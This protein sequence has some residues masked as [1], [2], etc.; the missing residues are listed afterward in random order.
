MSTSRVQQN[1]WAILAAAVAS[2]ALEAGWYTFFFQ[3]WLAGVGR[4]L[5]WS[6]GPGQR[7]AI[8]FPVALVAAALIATSI[9]CVTQLTGPQT[10]LR[11][12]K[13]G[14]L[15]WFGFVFTTLIT[16]YVFEVKPRLF[17]IN[18]GF[19]LVGFV[20]MG[21]IVGGWKKKTAIHAVAAEE[22]AVKVSE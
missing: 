16:E 2:F 22:R 6:N 13:V 10:A 21:A 15:L 11:G 14:A 1:Y 18:A 4:T 7:I 5:Q 9:S 17:E 19:W 20:V 12:I 8:Q 3:P